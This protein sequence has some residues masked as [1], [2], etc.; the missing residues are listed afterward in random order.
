MSLTKRTALATLVAGFTAALVALGGVSAATAVGPGAADR[1]LIL[2]GTGG[3]PIQATVTIHKHEQGPTLGAAADGLEKTVTTPVIEGVTFTAERIIAATTSTGAVSFDLTTNAGWVNASQLTLAADGTWTFGGESV[4]VQKETALTQVTDE[5]GLATFANVPVGL[6]LFTET[7]APAGVT[8]A[9][10]WVMAAPMTDPVGDPASGIGPNERWNYDLHV[11]PK[12]D[13][14]GLTKTVNDSAATEVGDVVSWTI[15]GDIPLV[16][17]AAFNAQAAVSAANLKFLAPTAFVVTDDLDAR[18]SPAA[19]SP[20]SVSLLGTDVAIEAADYTVVWSPVA[21]AGA[22]L[23]VTFTEQ[24]LAKLGLAASTAAD[25]AAAKVQVVLNTTVVTLAAPEGELATIGDGIIANTAALYPNAA[26]VESGTPVYS[27]EVTSLWGDIVIRKVDARDATVLLP[28]AEF[29][30]FTS[31]GA[32]RA[33]SNAVTIN[34]VSTFT[35][36]ADGTVRISGLRQS[37]H[38][39][40]AP[41]VNPDDWQYYWIVETG[42][43]TGYELLAEPIKVAVTAAGAAVE[44]LE[45][46]NVPSNAGFELPLTGGTGTAIFAFAGLS[47]VAAGVILALRKRKLATS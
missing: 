11:Y 22:E 31:E 5:L 13:K 34:N 4:T 35:T 17:N 28:G 24:G 30:V 42:A 32:A 6:Y 33:Q 29:K 40:G 41:I 3:A 10:P 37:D 38:V 19:T 9:A 27:N 20:V 7:A 12:N 39:N 23:T 43:P 16:A 14:T 47:I 36:G 15:T 1:P 25:P 8:K 45:V 21:E 26:A 46:E 2:P 44:V 18:L